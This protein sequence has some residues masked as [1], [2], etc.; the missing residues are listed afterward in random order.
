MSTPQLTHLNEAGDAR[1]VDVSGK[2]VTARTA[3]ATGR[4]LL[5]PATLSLLRDGGVPKGDALATARIAAF[6]SLPE[7]GDARSLANRAAASW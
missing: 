4:V 7:E 5:A 2:P 3:R 1:M 6:A